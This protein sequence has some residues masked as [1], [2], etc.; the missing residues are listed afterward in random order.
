VEGTMEEGQ[1]HEMRRVSYA[2]G[3]VQRWGGDVARIAKPTTE[4]RR[5]ANLA[6]INTDAHG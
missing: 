1:I 2:P 3:S 6:R 4:A 5:R